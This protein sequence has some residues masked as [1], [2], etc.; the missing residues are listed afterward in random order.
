MLHLFVVVYQV[1][2]AAPVI[3]VFLCFHDAAMI[4][5]FVGFLAEATTGDHI[6]QNPS[7]TQKTYILQCFY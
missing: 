6:Y 4:V 5:M 1:V 7:Y 2:S 3:A